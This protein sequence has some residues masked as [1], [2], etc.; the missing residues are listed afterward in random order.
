MAALVRAAA[1]EIPSGQS[2][3]VR[4]QGRE[5]AVFNAGGTFFAVKNSCPHEAASLERGRLEGSV[6]TCPG[7]GWRFD[8]RTG[9]CLDRPLAGLRCYR[10]EVRSGSIWIGLP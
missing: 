1:D 3:I 4:I 2:K 6:L 5:I 8:L 9:D 7:H 10:V